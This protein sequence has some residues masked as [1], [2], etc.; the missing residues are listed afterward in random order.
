MAIREKDELRKI[1]LNEKSKQ[2][3]DHDLSL[4][5]YFIEKP[6]PGHGINEVAKH[7]EA[8][9]LSKALKVTFSK[10]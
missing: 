8:K 4:T 1:Q 9:R 2:P 10:I 3:P 6:L 7:L 5:P